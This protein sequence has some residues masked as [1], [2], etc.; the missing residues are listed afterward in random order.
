MWEKK[1]TKQ[2]IALARPDSNPTT[3]W[4]S[5]QAFA[6]RWRSIA[7]LRRSIFALSRRYSPFWPLLRNCGVQTAVVS[8]IKHLVLRYAPNAL[9]GEEPYLGSGSQVNRGSRARRH[10]NMTP[11]RWQ[12]KHEKP[13]EFRVGGFE[14]VSSK[15]RSFRQHLSS[16]CIR[17]YRPRGSAPTSNFDKPWR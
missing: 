13:S 12:K 10:P 15:F 14:T 16:D 17:R 5:N 4:V 7:A 1:V 3:P 2:G 11:S 8:S 6:Q 9:L